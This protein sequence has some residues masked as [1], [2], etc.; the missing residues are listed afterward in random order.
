M[1]LSSRR[2]MHAESPGWAELIGARVSR[3]DANR[4]KPG[5]LAQSG[6]PVV[7]GAGRHP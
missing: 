5:D 7:E 2:V 6:P 4:S 1:S 3:K